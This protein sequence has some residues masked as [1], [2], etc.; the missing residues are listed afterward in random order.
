M[1]LR[2]GEHRVEVRVLPWSLRLVCSF[3]MELQEDITAPTV[4]DEGSCDGS[5]YAK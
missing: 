4:E 2:Q 3:P 5:T 1:G